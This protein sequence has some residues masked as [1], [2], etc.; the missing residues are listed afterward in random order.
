MK[1]SI[2]HPE[3]F[4]IHDKTTDL[5]SFGG[6]QEWYA[7]FWSRKSGCGPTSASNITAYLGMTNAKYR[8]LYT[9]LT[10]HKHDFKEHMEILF[11]YITPG[12]GGVNHV[13]KFTTGLKRYIEHSKLD[14][15]IYTFSVEGKDAASKNVLELREF[16]K[17]A[18]SSDC[19]IAF[20][21]LSNGQETT[22]QSWHWITIT[23]AVFTE[24][25]I[26]ATASDEGDPITFDLQKWYTSTPMH[27]GLVYIR[28]QEA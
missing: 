13:T 12:L 9:Q 6:D 24:D 4:N 2:K 10:L 20:L 15:N 18:L 28:P 22:L 8:K 25:T 5:V 7:K 17:E 26:M 19:P 21:N 3:L 23:S 14:V 1:Y 11:K 16:V 27:G